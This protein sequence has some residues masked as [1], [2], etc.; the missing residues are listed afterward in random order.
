MITVL[1]NKRISTETKFEHHPVH[2]KLTKNIFRTKV[3]YILDFNKLW[4][5][6]STTRISTK[7]LIVF[8][9][10]P[11]DKVSSEMKEEQ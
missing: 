1:W 5:Y 3:L 8:F 7:L 9:S 6:V 4:S 11:V 10:N 2:V